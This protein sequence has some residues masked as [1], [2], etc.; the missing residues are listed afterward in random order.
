LHYRQTAL[1][2]RPSGSRNPHGI[3]EGIRTRGVI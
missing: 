3:P 2:L 1:P